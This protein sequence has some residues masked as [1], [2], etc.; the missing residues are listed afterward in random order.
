MHTTL[1]NARSSALFKGD[2]GI[3]LMISGGAIAIGG[4]VLLLL[5]RPKKLLPGGLEVMPTSQGAAAS[6]SLR[7]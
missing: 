7:F 4:A 6:Y 2:L 5:N 1:R 3:G